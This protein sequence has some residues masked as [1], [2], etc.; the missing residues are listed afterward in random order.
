M[1]NKQHNQNIRKDTGP[2]LIVKLPALPST[3]MPVEELLKIPVTIVD[4]RIA[5]SL[6]EI[7]LSDLIIKLR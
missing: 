2:E 6:G 4:T 7:K 3:W 5:K 1:K